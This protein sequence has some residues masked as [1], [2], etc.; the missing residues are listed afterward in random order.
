M[1]V[2]IV[3]EFCSLGSRGRIFA[4]WG[5]ARVPGGRT[6]FMQGCPWMHCPAKAWEKPAMAGRVMDPDNVN[7]NVKKTA[8]AVRGE[9][10]LR[11]FEL[12]KEGKKVSCCVSLFVSTVSE[13]ALH[14]SWPFRELRNWRTAIFARV[15]K[16]FSGG[17]SSFQAAYENLSTEAGFELSFANCTWYN[18]DNNSVLKAS[19][20]DH[21]RSEC[22]V[23]KSLEMQ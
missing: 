13:A 16:Q 10:Y 14:V 23:R 8:Y 12:Q 20:A 9:L 21:S 3:V 15:L 17:F 11:A 2:S 7:P 4:G 6:L 5:E 1:E 19:R 22:T 18:L